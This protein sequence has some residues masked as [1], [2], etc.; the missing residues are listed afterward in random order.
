M[1]V[2][3]IKGVSL[4]SQK[5]A[6]SNRLCHYIGENKRVVRIVKDTFD[7]TAAVINGQSDFRIQKYALNLDSEILKFEV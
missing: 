6:F 4:F 3:K 2:Q 1:Y 7:M 5:D